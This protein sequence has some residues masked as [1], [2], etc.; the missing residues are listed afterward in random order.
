MRFASEACQ[1]VRVRVTQD[2]GNIFTG[3]ERED[4]RAGMSFGFR[5]SVRKFRICQEKEE[6]A[7]SASKGGQADF[8][9]NSGELTG[10]G[11][12]LHFGVELG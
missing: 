2:V 6:R 5:Y 8:P 9:V 7:F 4:A 10:Q 3:R 12:V 1:G 11:A